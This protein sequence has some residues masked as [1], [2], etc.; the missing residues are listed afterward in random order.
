[1]IKIFL[2]SLFSL[3]LVGV[4]GKACGHRL[5][6]AD[7]SIGN[8]A[9]FH[10]TGGR[11]SPQQPQMSRF[12]HKTRYTRP[13]NPVFSRSIARNYKYEWRRR[14]SKSR[15]RLWRFFIAPRLK[16]L[17][18]RLDLTARRAAEAQ[19]KEWENAN[20]VRIVV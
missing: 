12:R 5:G 16:V 8:P 14:F 4:L 3:T 19:V 17:I 13:S 20:F 6:K 10:V 11:E 15:V 1:M 7:K 2:L 18:Y 9:N